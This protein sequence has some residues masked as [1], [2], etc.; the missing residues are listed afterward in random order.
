MQTPFTGGC[1][2]GAIRYECTAQPDE[3][4]MFKC[5][6]RDCQRLSGGPYAA[7]VFVPARTFRI[8]QGKIRHHVTPSAAGGD[9]RRGFCPDCGSR[10]TGGEGEGSDHIGMT[11]SS[12]DDPS[13]FRPQM[14]MWTDDVQPW[15]RLDP[16]IP[17]FGEYPPA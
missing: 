17:H 3:I 8:T 15:D 7:V 10:L 9:H 13:G 16:D 1:T 14:E 5:H 11:A 2:C 12:L 6:C 4:Q